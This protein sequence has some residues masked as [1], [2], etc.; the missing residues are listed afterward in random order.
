MLQID[1]VN[2]QKQMQIK[3]MIKRV[4]TI[5]PLTIFVFVLYIMY[6]NFSEADV[7]KSCKN[8]L[9]NG[10]NTSTYNINKCVNKM[11]EQKNVDTLDRK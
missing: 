9:I 8:F 10:Y 4:L 2:L 1:L 7:W 11:K 3:I 6:A 5:L